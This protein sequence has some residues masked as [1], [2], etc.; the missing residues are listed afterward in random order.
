MSILHEQP[1]LP[2]LVI[3]SL[4]AHGDAPC[5]HTAGGLLSYADVRDRTETAMRQAH[6]FT[7]C[8][9]AL[10]AQARAHKPTST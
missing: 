8:R 2:H 7:V 5:I 9:L 6:V 3:R 1:L 10:E 4:A